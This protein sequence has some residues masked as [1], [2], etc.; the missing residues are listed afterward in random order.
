MRKA[1]V[2]VLRIGYKASAEQF[3]PRDLVEYAVLAEEVGLDSAVVSDHFLPWRHEGGHAPS[4]LTWLAAAGERTSRIT[5]GTSVLTPTFRYNPA[6]LAQT[7]ATLGLLYPGRI[8]LGVGTGEA[9]NE[10]AVSGREWPE[11][12]ERYA[13]LRESVRLIRELWTSEEEV[14]FQGEYYTTV[15][16][17][18]YDRPQ[19]PIPIYVAAG[20][21]QMAKYAGRA[22]DGFICTSGKGMEL[23][24]EKLIPSLNEGVEAAGKQPGDVD[25]MIEIKMSYDRDKDAALENTRFWAPLSLT[26]EQKHTVDS[27]VEMERLADELPIEQVAKRW[28]VASDPDEAIE[29][30]TPYLDAGLNH[31]VFHGPGHDQRRFLTQFAEDVLPKLRALA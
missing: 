6:V 21:P 18:I 9:L 2:V 15:N 11:F 29:Q 13:R 25:R 27:A 12:K 8:M 4:A 19:T 3:G 30:I 20:G 5:L 28:I 14:S 7:F 17:T 23:Y 1:D 31:L 26:A 16:A 22:G 24:T 10:I